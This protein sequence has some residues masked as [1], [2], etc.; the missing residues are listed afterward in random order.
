MKSGRV[1]CYQ[2]APKFVTLTVTFSG[3]LTY[4][5]DILES[6]APHLASELRIFFVCGEAK[7]RLTSGGKA[8]M[9]ATHASYA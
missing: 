3:F 4:Q 7:P 8:E 5:I 6:V 9:P 2:S 1:A